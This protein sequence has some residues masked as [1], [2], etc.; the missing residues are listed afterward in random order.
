M[1]DLH[2]ISAFR[3]WRLASMILL[4]IQGALGRANTL[5]EHTSCWLLFS[6]YKSV[7]FSGN[8]LRVVKAIVIKFAQNVLYV[9]DK[10]N[11]QQNSKVLEN[12][13]MNKC[14]S[15][16]YVSWGEKRTVFTRKKSLFSICDWRARQCTFGPWSEISWKQRNKFNSCFYCY[17]NYLNF[18][19]KNIRLRL[20]DYCSII[21]S[22]PSR[23][24]FNKIHSTFLREIVNYYKCSFLED[25]KEKTVR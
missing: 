7:N 12:K 11:F 21:F 5:F 19:S 9:N 18:I 8:W 10:T 13:E 1:Q 4:L 25:S 6:L 23:R 24:L 16:S 14:L 17:D 2:F 15:K 22:I 20:N 3:R